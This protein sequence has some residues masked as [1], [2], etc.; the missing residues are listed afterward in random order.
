MRTGE[1]FTLVWA[2]GSAGR[3]GAGGGGAV[4]GFWPG[5]LAA[6]GTHL[7]DDAGEP[8]ERF[9][10]GPGLC[11]QGARFGLPRLAVGAGFGARRLAVGTSFG[12]V[13]VSFSAQRLAVGT[14]FGAHGCISDRTA[15]ISSRMPLSLVMSR[16]ASARPTVTMAM[17]SW[18][19]LNM[20]WRF[21]LGHRSR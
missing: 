2:W 8:A 5:T 13:G 12:A 10:V 15:W 14:G 4:A 19:S 11:A 6:G 17:V 21:L 9:P 18:L 20:G 1:E 3:I 16:P 7:L